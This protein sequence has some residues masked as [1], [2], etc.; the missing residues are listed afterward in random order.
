MRFGRYARKNVGKLI[1]RRTNIRVTKTGIPRHQKLGEV[2]RD[3]QFRETVSK[4]RKTSITINVGV[5]KT[6]SCGGGGPEITKTQGSRDN[7]SCLVQNTV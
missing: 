3:D 7:D 4:V 5:P 1:G 2:L 6:T